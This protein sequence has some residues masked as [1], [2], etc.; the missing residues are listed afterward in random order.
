MTLAQ[1][2]RR[3]RHRIR[4][5]RKLGANCSWRVGSLNVFSGWWQAREVCDDECAMTSVLTDLGHRHSSL[6]T[7]NRSTSWRS[8]W[9]RAG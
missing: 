1:V 9:C 6:N 2:S 7:S 8:R 3:E 4:A 5:P